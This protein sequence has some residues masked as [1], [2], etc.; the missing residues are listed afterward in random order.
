MELAR[1]DLRSVDF[2]HVEE[3]L[4]MAAGAEGARCQA[5]GLDICRSFDW[6]RFGKNRPEASY[7]LPVTIPGRITVPG[8]G[9]ELSLELIDKAETFGA[10]D[11]VYNNV[12]GCLDWR[13]LSGDLELRNWQPGDRYWPAG[14]SGVSREEKVADLFQNARIPLWERGRWPVLTDA[15]GIIWARLFGPSAGR[16]AGP[17]SGI[18]LAVSVT[19][20]SSPAA[21]VTAE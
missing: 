14:V 19:Q 9:I 7:R 6:V 3:V 16:A 11:S 20:A 18:I 13:R 8:T 1:G 10:R 12:M 21:E 5:P 17:E 4:A 15:S 2:H